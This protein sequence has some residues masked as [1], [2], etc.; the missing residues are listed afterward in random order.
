[1]VYTKYGRRFAYNSAK[2][3][4]YWRIPEKLMP[5]ILELDQARIRQ[6]A[7]GKT[8]EGQ[9][10]GAQSG[11]Q[12]ENRGQQPEEPAHDYDS[13]EYE[14][15]EVTDNEDEDDNE[16]GGAAKRQRTEDGGDNGPVEFTEADI[17]AQL[18]ALN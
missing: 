18:P 17:A 12:P 4:S 13:S 7:M 10:E 15:V 16:D 1:M 14:E 11:P 9:D 6:K 8:S 2:N 3:T 5:A